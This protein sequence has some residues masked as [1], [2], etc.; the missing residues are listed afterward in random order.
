MEW[1]PASAEGPP[2]RHEIESDEETEDGGVTLPEVSV[3][4]VDATAKGTEARPMVCLFG[5]RGA[6]VLAATLVHTNTWP[7]SAIV[8]V[9]GNEV[10]R[11]C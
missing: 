5:D 4:L 2:P 9:N 3:S 1:D 8:R 6:D 11:V 7:T 10:R